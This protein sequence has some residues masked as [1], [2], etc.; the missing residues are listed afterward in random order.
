MLKQTDN[1]INNLCPKFNGFSIKV[2]GTNFGLL[3]QSPSALATG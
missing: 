1:P 3:P 2:N